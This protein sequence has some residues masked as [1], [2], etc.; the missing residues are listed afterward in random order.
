MAKRTPRERHAELVKEIAAHD[1]RYHV[2]DD[3]VI[4]DAEYDALYAELRDLEAAH[5]ELGHADSPTQRVGNEP[6]GALKTV[7]HVAPMMSLDNTYDEADLAEFLR[8]V[9]TGLRD[10]AE[11]EFC[12]EPKLDGA[13]VEVLYRDGRLVA[14]STRG[15]GAT[16]EDIT[17]NLRTIRSLPLGI[18]YPGPLTLRAEIVIYRRDLARINEERAALG[19]APF[20]NPRN[21]ASGS[22]RMLDPRVVARRGLRAVVWQVVE[23]P[24]L[25]ASHSA[26]LDR[27]A[28]L[29]LPT[30]RKHRVSRSQAEILAAVHA[31]DGE[32]RDYPYETDG[33]VVKVNDFSQQAILGATAKFPRWAIAYKFGAER[34]STKVLGIAVGVGR[35]GT[36]TPVAQLE[37]VELAGTVV[38][39]A[40]LHN[41]QIVGSLDVRIGDQVTIEKAGEIIPQVVSVHHTARSGAEVPFRMP[42]ACPSCGTK[43]ERTPGEV[44]VRCPNPL[45]PDQVK[46]SI[47]HFTRRF[48]MDIDHLGESLIEQLVRT[49][50]VK[51]VAD[52]YDLDATRLEA[53]ERM[54]KKSAE[55]VIQSIAASKERT[56]D[57]LLTGLGIEH[58]GQVA[59]RQLAEAVG[60]LD[61]L[62]AWKEDEVAERLAG[63]SGFGPKMV[64]SV[65]AFLAHPL[66]RALLEKLHE[67]GVSRPQPRHETVADGPLSGLSFC[68]TGVLS[69]RREDVHADIRK[70]GGEVHDK[71]KKGTSYL[72]AGDK[73]GKAKLDG[74]KKFGAQVIDETGLEALIRGAAVEGAPS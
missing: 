61:A 3:P 40:S 39:R 60:S 68:V 15:D 24:A 57:R 30:H 18:D 32:R 34:A 8:R 28:E 67:R 69:R 54:G 49:G 41:E 12:V 22:L 7:P 25:A 70:A 16:G 47:F 73:V 63:A 66:E 35:T 43:V 48:A 64:E 51:D 74:A 20:A 62:L 56:L 50:L 23:G 42:D 17:P 11:V 10:D 26:A 33:A 27:V 37:P 72:V 5:P 1:Y 52:L 9:R 46:G 6:R 29:G 13:S 31:F 4:T 2:L 44:A 14:G 71:V 19:E 59:A 45:C 36:L 53:L 21:A 58:V 65:R 38:S 55:N